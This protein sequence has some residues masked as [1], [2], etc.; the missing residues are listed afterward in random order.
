MKTLMEN[1]STAL[2]MVTVYFGVLIVSV[3]IETY[4]TIKE[5]TEL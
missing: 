4:F 5:H 2:A 3:I 1:A